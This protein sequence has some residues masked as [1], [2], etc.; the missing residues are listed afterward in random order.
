MFTWQEL[1]DMEMR[2]KGYWL[3]QADAIRRQNMAAIAFGVGAGITAAFSKDGQQALDG[4]ELTQTMEE[5]KK[6]EAESK[7]GLIQLL[8]GG[9]GV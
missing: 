9:K 3:R 4:L 1:V 6:Q 8:G 5:T 7:W 2:Q